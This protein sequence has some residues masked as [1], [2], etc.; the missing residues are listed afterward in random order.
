MIDNNLLSDSQIKKIEIARQQEII[1]QQKAFKRD[2]DSK[3][4]E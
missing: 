2:A 1:N 4:P 3:Q